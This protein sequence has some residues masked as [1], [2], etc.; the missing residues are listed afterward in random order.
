MDVI[1]EVTD[2]LEIAE[3]VINGIEN[4]S[5]V[6]EKLLLHQKQEAAV[7][8]AFMTPDKLKTPVNFSTV[9]V[10]QLEITPD[11]FVKNSPGKSLL[12][13]SRRRSTIGV[14][15]SPETNLLIR[16]IA[17][18]RNLKNANDSPLLE[19]SPSIQQASPFRYRNG[20][21][22]KER[23]SAFQSAFHQ[24]KE[25]E[26]KSGHSGLEGEFQAADCTKNKS[27]KHCDQPQLCGELP[28][29]HRRVSYQRDL[30]E[31]IANGEKKLTDIQ[32]CHIA[33]FPDT[34]RT[35]T[36][37][38]S[39]TDHSKESSC[40]PSVVA[41]SGCSVLEDTSLRSLSGA[42][43]GKDVAGCAEEEK[44][45]NAASRC[46][47]KRGRS[48]KE[49]STE[50]FNEI[51]PPVAPVYKGDLSSRKSSFLRSVLKKTPVKLL[52]ESL[53]EHCDTTGYDGKQS[54]SFSD[55]SKGCEELKNEK[56]SLKG[57]NTW[58]R[59]RVT[60]GEE[61]SPEVFDESL[62]ANTPLR[63]GG[64][65]ARQQD[66]RSIHP[67]FF[68]GLSISEAISQPNFE[69]PEQ[70]LVNMEPLEVSFAV[71]GPAT[72][73][74]SSETLEDT[75][76]V[77]SSNKCEKISP[78]KV[79]RITRSSSKRK[80]SANVTEEADFSNLVSTGVKLDRERKYSR[81]TAQRTKNT[82]R[83]ASKQIE[84][85]VCSPGPPPR[86][87]LRGLC[88]AAASSSSPALAVVIQQHRGHLLLFD[89]SS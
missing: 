26:E 57:Q 1:S 48:G 89:H 80:Q 11:S 72:N 13:K 36:C 22:L 56:S 66:V 2:G 10:E 41:Q 76:V 35:Y 50:P 61:L 14:R 15:G 12:K 16:Y 84:V 7:D 79:E 28:S 81:K 88:Q 53:Q 5:L 54:L 74:S 29:K 59:K 3:P 25:N 69:E 60:F 51:M 70:N 73:S 55:L 62:P 87:Q 78:S 31:N 6:D 4:R 32:I 65:P 33:T 68:P 21:S 44:A 82:N 49:L 46:R 45:S 75:D 86:S 34:N 71:L 40:D 52:L 85:S 24:V 27:P 67:P 47:G 17:Q 30:K 58:H 9:T 18:Q 19:A 23:I 42:T 43:R 8:P 63:K 37:E 38:T 20:D 39:T 77:N 83:T 64:T